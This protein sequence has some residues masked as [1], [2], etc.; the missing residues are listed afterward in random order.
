LSGSKSGFDT[1][2]ASLSLGLKIMLKNPFVVYICSFGAVL[3]VYQLGWSEIYPALSFDL[4]IFFG[5]T[6]LV[7]AL[8]ARGVSRTVR[9][10]K[11][12]QPGQLPKY[13]LLLL[14]VCF[15]ADI[16][17]T[18]GIPLI[19]VIDRQFDYAGQDL[20]VPHLHVFTVTF[21]SAFSTIRFADYLYSK[22]LR[23]LAEAILPL[24]YFILIFYRGPILICVVSWVFVFVIQRD[25]IGL[26]RGSVVAILFLVILHLFGVFGNLREGEGAI[27]ALG[28]P[29]AAFRD[30]AIPRTYFWTYIYLTSPMANLQLAVDTTTP[31]GG[32]AAEFV[33]S[34]MLPDF[35]SKRILP[36]LGAEQVK[37]PQVAVG[38]SVASLYGR[39]YVY[40]G[41]LGPVLLF[42][43]LAGLILLYLRLIRH[44]PY[45]VPCLALLNTLI[46]FCTFQNMI[47]F[48]GL[49]L[50]LVWPL[51]L[52]YRPFNR[53]GAN[54]ELRPSGAE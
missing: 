31:E 53:R 20:G 47:A 14:L 41:W 1:F 2:H 36:L 37:P 21:A 6:F 42:G 50:Q 13:T 29:T 32:R 24:V 34:E 39:S 16:I 25:R 43:V 33:V 54:L 52:S 11:E 8:L 35:V 44:S 18:G 45:R 19:M 4:L 3:A 7:S 22:R 9:Q 12:Y 5:L 46:V 40:R 51:F 49:M 15:A 10:T 17:Y 30:S 48:A 27:E 26:L 28:R 23:Y 38:L